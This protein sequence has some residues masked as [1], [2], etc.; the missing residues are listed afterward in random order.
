MRIVHVVDTMDIGGAEVIVATLC[1]LHRQQGH[2]ASVVC[3]FRI[4]VLGEQLRAEGFV[5]ECV[6]PASTPKLTWRLTRRFRDIKPHVI[7]CHNAMATIAAAHA[8]KAMHAKV[9]ST[10][11]GL[12]AP[13]HN[14]R[15]EIKF[16]V[17]GMV[18]NWVVGVCDATTSNLHRL[19]LARHSHIRRVYNGARSGPACAEQQPNIEFT[20]VSVGRLVQL[21]DFETLLKAFAV[22]RTV[23]NGLE[24][25]IVGDGPLASALKQLSNDLG[26]ASQVRFVGEASNVWPHLQR[27]SLFV[28]SSRNEG[29]PMS[30]LEAM[31][32]GLPSVVTD[33]GGMAE[34][35]KLTRAGLIVPVANEH[36]FAEAII[37]LAKTP[38]VLYT[39]GKAASSGYREHFTSERMAAEYLTLYRAEGP[40][41]FSEFQG[42]TTLGTDTGLAQ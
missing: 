42:G 10:R 39:M 35:V 21:K 1:R 14:L 15:C 38:H 18:C 16:C 40:S 30:L 19:P 9:V 36:A 7:H 25:I 17:A 3:L 11:H 4:G 12:V 41:Y 8:G 24:L 23:L 27:A 34:A 13:P 37:Q 26:I 20:L 5:V 2:D 29:L 33:V 6:G 22:A 32:V 31:S 28:M